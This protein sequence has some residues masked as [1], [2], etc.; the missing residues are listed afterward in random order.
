MYMFDMESI[1]LKISQLRKARNMTQME[2]ADQLNIS[3]QAISNWERGA[4]MPDIAKLPELAQILEVSI[5]ELLGKTFRILEKTA[6]GTIT[7]FLR[8]NEISTEELEE[9]APLLKPDQLDDIF[10]H[11]KP[12]SLGE[13]T[14]LA[15]FISQDVLDDVALKLAMSD[16]FPYICNL[17]PFLSGEAIEKLVKI[18]YDKQGFNAL[19]S[20]FPFM[21]KGSLEK[22][23][24]EEFTKTG[25]H[26][27]SSIAPFL[28]RSFLNGLAKEVIEREGIDAITPIIPFIDQ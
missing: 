9:V 2:L 25:I 17:A 23:A 15:P 18:I 16:E 5:D 4:S 20:L 8:D 11:V 21:S 19:S 10:K 12:G 3:F 7:E 26:N 6:E 22:I 1:G 27:I 14:S 13:L 24:D 28:C